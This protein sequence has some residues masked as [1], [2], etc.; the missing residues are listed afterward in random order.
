MIIE[1]QEAIKKNPS[2]ADKGDLLSIMLKDPL[3]ESEEQIVNESL[4]FFLAGALTQANTISNFICFM[5]QSQAIEKRVRE[6]LAK[7][8]SAFNDKKATL[9]DL[10]N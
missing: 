8:F 2:E 7:N 3:F 6:S 4:T 5:L 9:E 1:K 10:A